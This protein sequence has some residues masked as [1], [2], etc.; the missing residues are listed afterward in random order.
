MIRIRPRLEYLLEKAL[1]REPV[2]REEA[3]WLLK[4]VDPRSREMYALM[5]TAN[6]LTRESSSNRGIQATLSTP[7]RR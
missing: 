5:G 2:G 7:Y 6:Q 4:E 3:A 1:A